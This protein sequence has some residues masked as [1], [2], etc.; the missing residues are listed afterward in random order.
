MA[1][2][3]LNQSFVDWIDTAE[4]FT[5]YDRRV[6][7]LSMEPTGITTHG[8]GHFSVGGAVGE[9]RFGPRHASDLQRHVLAHPCLDVQHVLVSRGPPILA[10]SRQ[11]RLRVEQVA[12]TQ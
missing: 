12:E 9:V 11:A 10:P 6:Q 8:G 7:L 3:T 2:Q 1:G 4:I 5:E